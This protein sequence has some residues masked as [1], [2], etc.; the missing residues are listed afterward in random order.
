MSD[1][2]QWFD[3]LQ[4]DLPESK[5]LHLLRMQTGEIFIGLRRG[6]EKMV[7]CLAIIRSVPGFSDDSLA[8]IIVA[9]QQA[10]AIVGMDGT[11]VV[12]V[13]VRV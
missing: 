1:F 2:Q 6:K 8:R 7:I 12:G 10:T 5:D 9:L 11:A 4:I 13:L 3:I